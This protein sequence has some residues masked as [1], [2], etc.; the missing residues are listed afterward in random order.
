MLTVLVA[1]AISLPAADQAALFKAA[2]FT[3]RGGQWRSECEDPGTPSYEPGTIA[4]AEDLNGDGRPEAVVT[5]GSTFCYGNT[6]TAF[7][8]LTRTAAGKWILLHQSQGVAEFLPTRGADRMPDISVGGPGFCFPV[9]RW[10]GRRYAQLHFAYEGKP[11][12]PPR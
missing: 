11:C 5:E 1:A 3:R 6:G 12:T 10:N 2:G 7:W 9:L 4:R 8:L